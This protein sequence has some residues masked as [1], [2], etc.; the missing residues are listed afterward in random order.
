[1]SGLV[2]ELFDV[3]VEAL[4]IRLG[5]CITKAPQRGAVACRHSTKA[6]QNSSVKLGIRRTVNSIA[7]KR[8]H[9]LEFA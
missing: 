9:F 8:M 6:P 5:A 7:A 2:A 3:N 4:R 1:M